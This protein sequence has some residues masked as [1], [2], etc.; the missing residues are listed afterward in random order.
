MIGRIRLLGG[1]QISSPTESV[2]VGKAVEM[3]LLRGPYMG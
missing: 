2:G 1:I 3:D